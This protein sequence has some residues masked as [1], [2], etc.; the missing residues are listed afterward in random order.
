ML[1]A[2]DAVML[3]ALWQFDVEDVLAG[4]LLFRLVYC[5]APFAL[6]AWAAFFELRKLLPYVRST[7]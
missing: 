1:G 6:P 3:V 2:F 7:E 5:I 4:L